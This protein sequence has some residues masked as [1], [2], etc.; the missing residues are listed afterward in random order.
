MTASQP[1]F[2]QDRMTRN[3]RALIASSALTSALGFLF[4][5]VAARWFGA[6]E[7]GIG[8]ALVTATTLIA[9]VSTLGLRNGLV[10][11]LP[12][13]G[14]DARQL[15]VRSYLLCSAV[16]VV[17]AL[18][19]AAGQPLWAPALS[20]LQTNP[21]HL[22]LFVV[23]TAGWT[24]FVLQDS[25]L[26]GLHTRTWI[27]TENAL[28]AI[29]K[30]ALLMALPFAAEWGVLLAWSL[31][32]LALLLPVNLLIHRRLL[33]DSGSRP[34]S[35]LQ[36]GTLIRFAAG[37]HTADLIRLAGSE[38]VVLV[39]LAK[40][41]PEL[42]ASFF[43]AA[44]MHASIGLITS[45]IAS[46]FVAEAAAQPSRARDLMRASARQS[47]VLVVPIVVVATIAAPWILSLFGDRYRSEGTAVF[48]LLLLSTIPQIF[49]SLAVG[50]ARFQ[51]KVAGSWRSSP[52]MRWL[53][54][55]ARSLVYQGGG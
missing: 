54:C 4:W 32:A 8:G 5:L 45:N 13:A 40:A 53:L 17:L 27:P 22:L 10:R 19:F 47:V 37:D 6:R 23:S 9:G 24:V 18:V 15:I 25:V 51:R 2:A 14:A 36:P 7:L 42:A 26:T 31:P 16:G 3:S 50:V 55:S 43:I 48:R 28:Y 35:A 34:A 39:V 49:A 52:S 12:E 46:A 20:T 21:L 33:H 1:A 11:F 38:V 44:T 30:L 41:G 29:A